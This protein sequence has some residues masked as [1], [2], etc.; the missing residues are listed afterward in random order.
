MVWI[1]VR[2]IMSDIVFNTQ[3]FINRLRNLTKLTKL[4]VKTVIDNGNKWL[5]GMSISCCWLFMR[6]SNVP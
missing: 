1:Q 5:T 4:G 3:Q 6:K 2:I